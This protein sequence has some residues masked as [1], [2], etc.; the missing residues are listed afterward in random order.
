MCV[1]RSSPFLLLSHSPGLEVP[2]YIYLFCCQTTRL[3]LGLGCYDLG[4]CACLF[5]NL[6]EDTGPHPLWVKTAAIYL[7]LHP[8]NLFFYLFI[9]CF[10]LTF[11][12][13]V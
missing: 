10:Y 7:F 5:I 2:Q 11:I 1:F 4:S 9:T 3:F 6:C 8:L 12:E 13:Y